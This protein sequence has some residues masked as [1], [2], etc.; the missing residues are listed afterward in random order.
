MIK[1]IGTGGFARCGKDTFCNIAANILRKNGYR[2]KQYS[3]AG[4]L[5]DEV[6]PFL[7]EN[8][9]VDV[10]TNDSELKADIRDF[11]VWYGTTWWRKR[12]PNRWIDKVDLNMKA[13]A[14][15][16]DIAIVSDVR[17]LNES[18]WVHSWNGYMVHLSSYKLMPREITSSFDELGPNEPLI[19]TFADAPNEQEKINDPI[20]KNASD[21]KLE[22]EHRSM[23][24]EEV[25]ADT[26]IN[27]TVLKSLNSWV[28]ISETLSL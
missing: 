3:F 21:F 8:C 18:D 23:T 2:V 24:P 20:V 7:L 17:Y 28:E 16:I 15:D 19:K 1:V 4:A 10:R 9:G 14:N 11:L 26:T 5:K 12:E 22:W 6:G 27:E 13:D 25:M